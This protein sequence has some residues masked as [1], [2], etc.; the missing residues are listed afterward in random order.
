MIETITVSKSNSTRNS[1]FSSLLATGYVGPV[2]NIME[3][4]WTD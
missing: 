2:N 4:G 3:K 1:I